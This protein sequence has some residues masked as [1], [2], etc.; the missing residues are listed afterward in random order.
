M[1]PETPDSSL[2][3]F[4]QFGFSPPTY[5]QENEYGVK[6]MDSLTSHKTLKVHQ[7]WLPEVNRILKRDYE[8]ARKFSMTTSVDYLDVLGFCKGKGVREEAFK[9]ICQS[10]DFD[11][12]QIQV[13]F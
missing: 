1:S 6:V 3:I 4:T 7:D 2:S 11:Y 5:L 10:L 9:A 13:F 8:D 12:K